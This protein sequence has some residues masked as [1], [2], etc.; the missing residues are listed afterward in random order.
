[1]IEAATLW[2]AAELLAVVGGFVWLLR[3]V[4]KGLDDDAG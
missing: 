2:H 3:L 4:I 1:M